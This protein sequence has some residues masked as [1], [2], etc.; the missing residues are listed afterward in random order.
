MVV[1][2]GGEE[3]AVHQGRIFIENKRESADLKR[4]RTEK[5]GRS[6]KRSRNVALPIRRWGEIGKGHA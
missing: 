5:G 4:P 3:G 1:I 6:K 2:H